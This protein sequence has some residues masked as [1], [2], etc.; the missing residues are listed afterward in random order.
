MF[1]NFSYRI[2][3]GLSVAVHVI[4]ISLGSAFYGN[5]RPEKEPR[6]EVTY[7][8]P[9]EI[10]DDKE[11][12]IES[13]PEK[14][15]LKKKETSLGNES[16]KPEDGAIRDA[17]NQEKYLDEEELEKLEEYIEYYEL[18]REK[19]KKT[20]ARNYA[21]FSSDGE[22]AVGA[23]FSL[24]RRGELVNVNIKESASRADSAM[25]EAAIRS[26]REAAPFPAFPETLD[27][28]ELTFNIAIV[29]KR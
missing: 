19:I 3:I 27:R 22:D 29:F 13:L 11:K 21:S 10:Y 26:I 23:T 2:A 8:V 4:G 12:I 28:A 1:Y 18:I 17:E 15:D 16:G 24:T 14:Y 5:E 25:K 20:A 7:L 6:A 9:E